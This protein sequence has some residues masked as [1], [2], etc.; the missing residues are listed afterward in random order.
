MLFE[1]GVNILL[2]TSPF[3]D[4]KQVLNELPHVKEIH[5]VSLKNECK[6]VLYLLDQK[7]TEEVKLHCIDIT[8]SK[9]S[10]SYSQENE[11]APLSDPLDYLYEANTSILKAGAF[12][13]IAN[14][15]KLRK[16]HLNSHLYTSHRLVENFP[17]RTFKVDS[18]CKFDKKELLKHFRIKKPISL[19][20]I[21]RLQL[22]KSVKK[23]V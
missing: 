3:L 15:F 6:E 20:E 18:I 19:E 17:G 1:K 13:S 7:H 22:Q 16:L 14:N 12:N 23:Q 11:T 2:K 8:Q 9:F 21:F 5:I 4:I 10:F